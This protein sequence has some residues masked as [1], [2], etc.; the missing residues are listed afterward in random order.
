MRFRIVKWVSAVLIALFLNWFYINGLPVTSGYEALAR[1]QMPQEEEFSI[2]MSDQLDE[3]KYVET[4]PEGLQ[5]EPDDTTNISN[6]N[7]QAAQEN[8]AGAEKNDTPFVE[9]EDEE[10]PKIIEGE[11]P[12]EGEDT[13]AIQEYS[14]Q[15]SS[16][17]TQPTPEAQQS[18][19]P[20][21]PQQSQQQNQQEEQQEQQPM[22][23]VLPSM[24]APSDLAQ[25]PTIPP[26]PPTP[27]FIDEEKEPLTEDGITLPMIKAQDVPVQDY[28]KQEGEDSTL[29]INI[30]PSVAQ[31]LSKAQEELKQQQ[32][33]N[34]QATQNPQPAQ[35]PTPQPMPRPR[36]SPKVL[37]GPLVASQVYAARMGPIG[38]D[39]KFSQ[40][41][42]Y[43][44]RM[45]ETIQL[46]WYSLLDDVTISQ[47]KRP[48]YVV[49]EYD[50]NAEGKVVEARVLETNAGQ[51]ATLLC[52]DAI[53][54]RAPFGPWTSQMV[55]Q[56][57]DQ[58][59]IR[60]KFV[61]L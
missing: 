43:L 13:P 39:A 38:F 59:T 20:T 22:P 47:E 41:G 16:Q 1:E 29:N 36:L 8:V 11:V 33:Q 23:D 56:L 51:L 61:Y 49:I 26:P 58:Q 34:P 52:K 3:M 6:R 32:Q 24:Q 17:Q 54:S 46:Q 53:E 2:D 40:F 57:G 15:T 48:A 5:N 18:M 42:Y 55:D 60:L 9:G 50:L 25:L 14:S 35:K 31:Q 21:P 10:S 7:Q 19:Q 4:N 44:Q 28:S 30:P 12:T 27:D 45:F 37:P